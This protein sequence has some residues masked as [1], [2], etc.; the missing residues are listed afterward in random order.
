MLA[1]HVVGQAVQLRVEN[2]L[3]FQKVQDHLHWR[4]GML[5]KGRYDELA[6]TYLLPHVVYLENRILA[7]PR[8]ADV[9]RFLAH[10][11]AQSLARKVTACTIR[12][13]AVEVPRAGRFRAWVQIADVIGGDTGETP[14]EA[15]Y[16]FHQTAQ[17][18]RTEMMD[19]TRLAIPRR[20]LYHRLWGSAS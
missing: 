13:T 17:G 8:I 7:Q 3:M 20:P 15:V 6:S 10:L 11:H 18:F 9:I 5:F 14:T 16:Y 19:F 1:L 2:S 4:S 12:L